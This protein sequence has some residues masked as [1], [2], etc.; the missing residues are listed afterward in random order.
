M[1][2]VTQSD[3]REPA[4]HVWLEIAFEEALDEDKGDEEDQEEIDDGDRMV[5]EA[6]ILLTLRLV[7]ERVSD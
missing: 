1:N 5:V 2:D 4:P 6:V 3:Q 7:A